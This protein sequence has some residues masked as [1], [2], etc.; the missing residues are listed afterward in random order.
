MARQQ[1]GPTPYQAIILSG[2]GYAVEDFEDTP[3]RNITTKI[4]EILAER[5]QQERDSHSHWLNK[6]EDAIREKRLVPGMRVEVVPPPSQQKSHP[7]F[8]AVIERI[9]DD[10]NVKLVGRKKP[11]LPQRLKPV[12]T[13]ST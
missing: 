12:E 3:R 1:L 6:R 4:G 10:Q 2:A 9:T 8:V 13:P 11:E 7:I 5:P